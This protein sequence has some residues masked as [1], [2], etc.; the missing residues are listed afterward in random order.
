MVRCVEDSL[1]ARG[2]SV[3]VQQGRRARRW[4][5]R[6]PPGPSTLRILCVPRIDPALANMLRRGLDRDG[7]EDFHIVGLDTPRNA[8]ETI[9]RLAGRHRPA[10]GRSRRMLAH[11]TMIEQQLQAQRR[12]RIPAAAAVALVALGA[13]AG[14]VVGSSAA[15]PDAQTI[16]AP[17]S[18][19]APKDAVAPRSSV[20][21]EP[22]LS[23]VRAPDPSVFE[24]DD[25][26]DERRDA[27][28]RAEPQSGTSI[29]P[30]R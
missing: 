29:V 12:W 3:W 6:V 13:T 7:R 28:T 10:P 11:P 1:R 30:S 18:I 14:A 24:D 5:R 21:P 26:P 25:E 9:E 27:D 16:A 8:V 22:V 15:T 4:V 17:T 20:R 19:A 2:Y 23:A